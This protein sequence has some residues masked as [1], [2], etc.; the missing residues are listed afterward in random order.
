MT[1]TYPTHRRARLLLTR[2]ARLA[3]RYARHHRLALDRGDLDAARHWQR[4]YQ[5]SASRCRAL[6]EL[7]RTPAAPDLHEHR[8]AFTSSPAAAC[9]AD[10][11][12]SGTHGSDNPPC[13]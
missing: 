3:E 11:T 9:G 12:H 10:A 2:E 7:L 6:G 8:G 4:E 1:D 13:P 5:L